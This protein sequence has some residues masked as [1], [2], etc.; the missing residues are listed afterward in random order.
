MAKR[1][2]KK[3]THAQLTPEQ[4][5]GIPKSMVIR[6]GQTSLANHSLNQLV[7]DFR[8]IM[9]PHTAIKLKERKSNKLKDFVVMCGPLGVTHLFMFTQSEKT[10]NVSLKIARTPQGPTVTFQVLDYS[11]GRDIKK[12]LKRPKSLNNDDVL[13][14]PLLVL[15]GFSTS[16]RSGEDDQD[17][18]VEKVIVSMFQNIFPPLNPART[19]LNSIKRVFMINKDRETGEI[20]MR[21]YFIDIREVEISRNLKR[22]YKAKNNLSKTV[23]NLH[24]KE[25]IS[26]LIL[27]HD[28]GAYTSESE[29]EDDAI[30]RVVDNQDVKAKHSQ[31]LKSQRTPVEKKDNKEREKETEEEDVEM[32]EPKPSENL[33][34]TP[35]KKAIKLTELGPRLTLKLVKIEEGICSGKVL[36]HEFVQKSSEEIKALEKR[37]AAKM[38]LKEQRKKEQEENIAKKK[39]VKDAKKQRKLERRKARAAEGGEGQGK[40]DAM[41]DDESSSS[42]SEHYG[43]VPEDLDS[44]LFSEV[45]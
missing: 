32:E 26:S 28:L 29:I 2:Q 17:V 8:Q 12:F 5:Q 20:S 15:N 35:R 6:V 14:P 44:D 1:R 42:D 41:S 4:E 31:S 13:N 19:S 24:R 9:Q 23:P 40:D 30:V 7:K 39:A 38:R 22:L 3:R 34:P 36:H 25:D 11:L 21:H 18:N 16:K 10:G 33:Q 37:H 43:S 27:D 45:E